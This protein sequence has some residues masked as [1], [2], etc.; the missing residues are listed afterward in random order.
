MK[1]SVIADPLF[2]DAEHGDYRPKPESAAFELGFQ[3]IGDGRI[4]PREKR[5]PAMNRQNP[6]VGSSG[7]VLR[8]GFLVGLVFVLLVMCRTS[9]AAEYYLVRDGEP[10][11]RILLPR[12]FGK[13]TVRA[14]NELSDYIEKMT[15]ARIPVDYDRSS[16]G[17]YGIPYEVRIM[18]LPKIDSATEISADGSEDS[19]TIEV[20]DDEFWIRGNSD[21]AVLYGVYQFLNDLGVRWFMPGEIGE[22]VPALKNI[23]IRDLKKTYKPSFRTRELDYSGYNKGHFN[24][25]AQERQHREYD[26]WLLRNKCHFARSIHWSELHGFDMNQTREESW[27]NLGSILGDID[28][29][30][31][32]ERFALVTRDGETKRRHLGERVQLCFTHPANIGGHIQAA[33]DYFTKRPEMLTYPAS[34]DDWSGF[35]ECP[36][37]VKA[38]GGIFPPDNPNRV[39]WKFMNAVAKGLRKKMPNKRIA[40]YAHYQLMTSPPDDVKAEPGVVAGTA[41]GSSSRSAITDPQCP[42]NRWYLAHIKKIAATGAEMASYQYTMRGGTPQPLAILSNT[43]TY[44]DLGYV[45]YHTEGLGRDEQRNIV[46]WVQAQLAWDASKDPEELLKTFCQEYYGAAGDDVR[47]VLE[48]ID[49]SIRKLPKVMLGGA[50]DT[51]SIMTDEVIREGRKTLAAALEKAS[52]R[53]KERLVRFNDTF[54][55]FCR[56]GLYVRAVWTALD[57]RTPAAKEQAVKEIDRFIEF[58]QERNLSETCSPSILGGA[59][60]FRKIEKITPTVTPTAARKLIGRNLAGTDKETLLKELFSFA[61]VPEQVGNLFFLPE[62]WKFKL[63]IHRRDVQT[64]WMTADFDDS[65]WQQLSTY[66]FFERQGFLW[67]N[68][69]FWYRVQFKAPAFPKNKRVFLRIGALDDEG[70]IY[71]NGKLTHQRWHLNPRDWESSFEIDVTDHIRPGAVNVIV[72]AGNDQAGVGGIWKP[73]ALY[74]K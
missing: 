71:V 13:A 62:I 37:C 39:V 21:T 35:C 3:P 45:W 11:A 14:A 29:E 6:W 50:G 52:D 28:L 46:S 19:F 18:L 36:N 59:K 10:K 44:H 68:G 56:R 53:E 60:E 69:A 12:V 47:T 33:V 5:R 72:V 25:K 64:A 32:P 23:K 7:G 55:M 65:K 48:L 1:H 9:L 41:H 15:G 38:N 58:W 27:H 42:Y 63:N 61:E 2:V 31:E 4:G 16:E 73:C 74:T 67:Y 8:K 17:R 49:G 51:Q 24:P 57:K 30:K 20:A 26:L 40:F 34:L 54:E 70:S 22:N 66:N 43:R